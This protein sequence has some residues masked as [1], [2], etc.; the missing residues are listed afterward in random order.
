MD[1]E[2]KRL[3]IK[4]YLDEKYR[5]LGKET[6]EPSNEEVEEYLLWADKTT[7]VIL[8]LLYVI[9]MIIPICDIFMT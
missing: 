5:I 6:S 4:S 3:Y 9:I 2:T 1:I 8:F 7:G